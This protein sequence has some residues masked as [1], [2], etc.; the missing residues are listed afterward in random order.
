MLLLYPTDSEALN[1]TG[2]SLQFCG[3]LGRTPPHDGRA[4][5][6][7][8]PSTEPE[9]SSP[10]ASNRPPRTKAAPSDVKATPRFI[11]PFAPERMRSFDSFVRARELG[12]TPKSDFAP[13][14][15][16]SATLWNSQP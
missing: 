7:G 14:I 8:A 15:A 6:L 3:K 13:L 9:S 1:C 12:N 16:Y 11:N 2:K 5:G 10:R 4:G